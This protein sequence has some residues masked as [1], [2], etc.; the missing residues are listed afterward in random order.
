MPLSDDPWTSGKCAMKAI[1][2][3]G[4]G[5]PAIVSPVGANRDVV[6]DGV[7][8]LHATGPDDW[9]AKLERI[10]E[11]AEWRTQLGREARTRVERLFSAEAHAPR[12]ARILWSLRR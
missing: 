5:L 10:L 12:L 4:V 8:G 6:E 3:M 2:Y 11:D 1:Q 7:C 9:A